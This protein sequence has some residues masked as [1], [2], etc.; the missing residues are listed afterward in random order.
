MIGLGV[1]YTWLVI[2]V[3]LLAA[4]IAVLYMPGGRGAGIR[5][6]F[7]ATCGLLC[8]L[9]LSLSLF[10]PYPNW[11]RWDDNAAPV[12]GQNTVSRRAPLAEAGPEA[13]NKIPAPG[14]AS[15]P[16]SGRSAE[17][18]GLAAV[19]PPN[20]AATPE[21][22]ASGSAEVTSQGGG[23]IAGANTA[24]GSTVAAAEES[25]PARTS[26]AAPPLWLR[27]LRGLP[28][29][30]ARIEAACDQYPRLRGFF[31]VLGLTLAATLVIGLTRLLVALVSVA[32]FR[33]QLRPVT[34]PRLLEGLDVV[35]A[36]AGCRTPVQLMTVG[37]LSSP[38]TIGVLR[39]VIIVPV[40][41][42]EW[43]D[44]QIQGVLAHEVGHVL[45]HDYLWWCLAQIV[46][47]FHFFNPLVMRLVY[48]LR[49]QQE[50]AA[51]A[52]AVEVVGNARHYLE[53]LASMAVREHHDTLPLTARTFLPSQGT[54]AS[55][56]EMLRA[57]ECSGFDRSGRG[58]RVLGLGL[59]L[60]ACLLAGV[61][62]ETQ[63]GMQP[64]GPILSR[65]YVP[66]NVQFAISIQRDAV[67]NSPQL[68]SW[69]EWVGARTLYGEPIENFEQLTAY[70]TRL[71]DDFLLDP[72]KFSGLVLHCASPEMARRVL[73]EAQTG[74]ERNLAGEWSPFRL[75][76][77]RGLCT[78]LVD[79]RIVI[80]TTVSE[81][82]ELS[83]IAN[84]K[85]TPPV[86]W[87]QAWDRQR[88]AVV[89]LMLTSEGVRELNA[90]VTKAAKS[91]SPSTPQLRPEWQEILA[92]L[93][94]VGQL[95]DVLL[96]NCAGIDAHELEL[97][98]VVAGDRDG[99]EVDQ[100]TRALLKTLSF[101]MHDWA[102]KE[103]S[104]GAA[105]SDLSRWLSHL[106]DNFQD[107]AQLQPQTVGG[108]RIW[109][110]PFE[111][112]DLSGETELRDRLEAGH[113][114]AAARALAR[115]LEAFRE[116]YGRWPQT[117]ERRNP[118]EPP[119]SWRVALL[120]FLGQTELYDSYQ[121]D[122]AWDDPANMH[123]LA[124]MPDCFYVSG[125]PS[126]TTSW[127]LPG[128]GPGVV[129]APRLV[130]GAA[131]EGSEFLVLAMP[132]TLIPWTLPETEA[133]DRKLLDRI[134]STGANAVLIGP[135]EDL[136]RHQFHPENS[137]I[138]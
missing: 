12:A 15:L 55:R 43:S 47:V 73:A 56:I 107:Y 69:R 31:G 35:L 52:V 128:A 60:V 36:Q 29:L 116:A 118:T 82:L 113:G 89:R 101:R 1:A 87:Q 54:L 23:L 22:I 74:L 94:A 21:T 80:I 20:G 30:S 112:L 13:L 109:R 49:L 51:D 85:T 76:S 78:R 6:G 77:N 68:Q 123:V 62:I 126:S 97:A 122:K 81:E 111:W 5:R 3:T 138:R 39:P 18:D 103:T 65:Q 9:G 137:V 108:A 104:A 61:R 2:K 63:G 120:P 72:L 134:R 93:E 91:G 16:G 57:G 40:D 45:H 24:A 41:H 88:R 83:L 46:V 92:R 44:E 14:G 10:S 71:A 53:V 127:I 96:L 99:A 17:H 121:F 42:A 11:S 86:G 133:L 28:T 32:Q 8:I 129:E 48:W 58:K 79:E 131:P 115:G 95:T 64:E 90:K 136:L 33:R 25:S 119:H 124:R 7:L 59:A 102:Q 105:Q 132:G 27:T 50:L 66:S 135:E 98:A 84:A 38:A 110:G 70:R 106:A 67:T 100:P 37:D 130:D 26:P 114:P 75:L 4:L 117:S 34:E 19:A 125:S